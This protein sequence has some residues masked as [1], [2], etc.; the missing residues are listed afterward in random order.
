[1]RHA[2]LLA[3]TSP[4]QSCQN[5]VDCVEAQHGRMGA[6]SSEV[7]TRLCTEPDLL[8]QRGSV[9]W[10]RADEALDLGVTPVQP[11]GNHEEM[12][13]VEEEANPSQPDQTERGLGGV[14][15]PLI[16]RLGW[17]FGGGR[18]CVVI[19]IERRAARH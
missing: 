4:D 6:G 13:Q 1:M 15:V 18:W 19:D 8:S 16:T 7:T 11:E 14:A 3:T 17:S 5:T 2:W 10:S 12:T 9:T